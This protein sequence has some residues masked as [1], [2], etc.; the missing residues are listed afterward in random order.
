MV[1]CW[2]HNFVIMQDSRHSKGAHTS[3]H[4]AESKHILVNP[5]ARI[6]HESLIHNG[7][8]A[9]SHLLQY[10][11]LGS[12]LHLLW[13]QEHN[14]TFPAVPRPRRNG[15]RKLFSA[16]LGRLRLRHHPRKQDQRITGS[17]DQRIRGSEDQRIMSAQFFLRVLGDF[18]H[19]TI[20]GRRIRGS[21]VLLAADDG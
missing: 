14:F 21:Q 9:L 7:C 6:K 4:V 20:Q 18:D 1:I 5:F 2:R 10:L 3:R 17:Q 8:S 15:R 16:S 12:A 19:F 11:Q 13:D